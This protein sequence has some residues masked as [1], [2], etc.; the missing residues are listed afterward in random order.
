M[1][2]AAMLPS[3]KHPRWRL[4][5]YA[6]PGSYF[7]TTITHRRRCILGAVTARGIALSTAGSI[8][9]KWW[10]AASH[11]FPGATIDTFVVM[12]DHVH[13]IVVLSRT[14]D[15]TVGLSQVVGWAKQRS[16]REINALSHGP[17]PPIWQASFHDRIIRDADAV[18]RVRRY[19][20]AN[21]AK[22]WRVRCGDWRKPPVAR[23]S[24]GGDRA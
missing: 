7:V 14:P 9:H 21:P 13:A 4:H 20:V 24:V 23:H 12:P 16:A 2:H 8:V 3:R 19:I 22:A 17:Q 6:L 1:H 5:D 10:A 18:V 11:R 15:R